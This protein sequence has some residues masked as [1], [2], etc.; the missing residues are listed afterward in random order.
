M[1]LRHRASSFGLY[2]QI[3]MLAVRD[4]GTGHRTRYVL[5]VEPDATT[6]LSSILC[7]NSAR[8]LSPASWVKGFAEAREAVEPACR[9]QWYNTRGMCRTDRDRSVTR[10]ARS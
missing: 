10:R 3:T 9:R 5:G 7:T 4:A 8:A 2:E 6:A 1:D